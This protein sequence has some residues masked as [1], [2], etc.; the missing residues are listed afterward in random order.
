MVP[1]ARAER[2]PSVPFELASLPFDLYQRHRLAQEVVER[3]RGRRKRLTIL[4]VGGA[5]GHLKKFLPR[6]R[7]MVLDL[8]TDGEGTELVADGRQLPFADRAMDVVVSLD[9]LE[10]LSGRQRPGFLRAL[11]RVSDDTVLVS[12]SFSGPQTE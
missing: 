4:D 6:D 11:A 9:T 8:E 2:E 5:P 10:H 1:K 3:I 7:I 12:A